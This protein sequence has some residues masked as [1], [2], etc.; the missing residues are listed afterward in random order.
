MILRNAFSI[1]CAMVALSLAA[2]ANTTVDGVPVHSL[3][4]NPRAEDVRAVIRVASAGRG[5]KAVGIAGIQVISATEMHVY[6]GAMDSPLFEVVTKANGK[7]RSEG[8]LLIMKEN[9][10]RILSG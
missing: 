6:R 1:S 2:C 4:S 9:F 10:W 8:G 5:A 3:I 7:W